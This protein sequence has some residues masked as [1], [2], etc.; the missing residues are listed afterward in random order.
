MRFL[1]VDY[2][3]KRIG[4]AIG[5]SENNLAS[6][7]VTVAAT[8]KF[9]EDARRV[10]D[11]SKDYEVDAFVVGMALN[12]DDSEGKQAK[13]SRKF[14]AALAEQSKKP[15]HFWDERLSS[16]AADELLDAG[17]FTRKKHKSR[18]DRVAAQVILQEFLDAHRDPPARASTAL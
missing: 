6:P 1:G 17:D 13:I 14:G 10:L 18:R 2:G 5:D 15:V 3:G 16:F 9:A 12:M 7:L 8:A 11:A 4:L